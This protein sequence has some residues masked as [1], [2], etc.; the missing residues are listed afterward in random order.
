M[1]DKTRLSAGSGVMLEKFLNAVNGSSALSVVGGFAQKRKS[2]H[3][4]SGELIKAFDESDCD[5]QPQDPMNA[6]S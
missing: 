2:H 4:N 6:P 1:Q 5:S 3:A